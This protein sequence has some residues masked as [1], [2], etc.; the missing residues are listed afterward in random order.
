MH[1][2]FK[3]RVFLEGVTVGFHH[4]TNSL[5]LLGEKTQGIENDQPGRTLEGGHFKLNPLD[6]NLHPGGKGREAPRRSRLLEK[7]ARRPRRFLG[8]DSRSDSRGRRGI[9]RRRGLSGR[10][11]ELEEGKKLL[12]GEHCSHMQGTKT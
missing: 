12:G 8:E 6:T 7:D 9:V 4:R 3:R 5:L 1:Y 11:P 10:M 2:P